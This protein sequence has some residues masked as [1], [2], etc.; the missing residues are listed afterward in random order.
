VT[1]A[2][3]KISPLVLERRAAAFDRGGSGQAPARRVLDHANNDRAHHRDRGRD[4]D[5]VGLGHGAVPHA[6]AASIARSA[7]GRA[8]LAGQKE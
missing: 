4:D 2:L 1:P 7:I 6:P 8:V 5:E 3:P